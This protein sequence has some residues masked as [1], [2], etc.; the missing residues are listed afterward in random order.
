MKLAGKLAIVTG[1]GRGIGRGIA[2]C[3]AK[4]GADIVLCDITEDTHNAADEIKA[5]GRQSLAVNCDVRKSNDIRKA[6][7]KTMEKFGKIDILVNNA[8]IIKVGNIIDLE[9]EDWD[10]IFDINVKGVFLFSKAIAPYMIK[11]KSGK[12]INISSITGKTA[13]GH[14]VAYSASKFAVIGFTQSLAQEL[15]PHNINVNAVC[16]GFVT[17]KMLE[18]LDALKSKETGLSPQKCREKRLEQIPLRRLQTPEDIG[19][20]VVFLASRDSDNITGQSINVCGG[21]EFH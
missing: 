11:Q 16:P 5:L 8:G 21:M 13:R 20:M 15:A 3:L 17:T 7:Q 10:A 6:A 1:S 14:G 18:Y 2:L 9:E 4:E 19:A 12:I